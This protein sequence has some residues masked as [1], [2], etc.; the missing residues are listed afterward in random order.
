MRGL[1]NLPISAGP[2]S[3]SPALGAP[4]RAFDMLVLALRNADGK[5]APEVRANIS[6]L[7]GHLGRPGVVPASRAQEVRNL[8]ESTRELLVAAAGEPGHVGSAAK[9]A[10][11][12]WA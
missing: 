2:S 10:L 8:Q 1:Q 3:D 5:V 9:K 12:G 7:V 4:R 11:E 6:A